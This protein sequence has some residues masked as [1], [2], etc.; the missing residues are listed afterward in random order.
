MSEH[1]RDT[2]FLRRLLQFEPRPEHQRLEETIQHCE[3]KERCVR[4]AVVLMTQLIV[5][6]LMGL[7]YTGVLLQDIPPHIFDLACKVFCILGL[8][9]FI[10]LL[11]FLVLWGFYRHE[12]NCRRE[13]CR[14]RIQQVLEQRFET[15]VHSGRELIA[16]VFEEADSH[17]Q[18]RIA[19]RQL[20]QHV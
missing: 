2:A 5:I 14:N 12:L 8:G 10:S 1:E 9:S 4:R 7:C 15:P 19:Q 20:L 13:E 3:E 17:S 16:S 11:T 6:A 18:K